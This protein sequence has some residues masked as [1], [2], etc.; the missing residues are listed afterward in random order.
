MFRQVTSIVIDQLPLDQYENGSLLQRIKQN[1]GFS[2]VQILDRV[3]KELNKV[4]RE[5]PGYGTPALLEDRPTFQPNKST[6]EDRERGISSLL[7]TLNE[8]QQVHCE[9]QLKNGN[10]T[11]TNATNKESLDN[12]SIARNASIPDQVSP[13]RG[14][15]PL[16]IAAFNR[17]F[18]GLL[19]HSRL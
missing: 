13:N 1:P 4:H 11:S 8:H 18:P 2:D 16:L 14:T 3:R 7:N 12:P 17:R 9:P 19:L 10:T 6:P 15:F 5:D